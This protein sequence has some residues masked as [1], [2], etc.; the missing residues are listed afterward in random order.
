MTEVFIPA[1]TRN[2]KYCMERFNAPV[3]FF[4]DNAANANFD[5]RLIVI[6]AADLSQASFMESLRAER[7]LNGNTFIILTNPVNSPAASSLMQSCRSFNF[8]DQIVETSE[9]RY[10]DDSNTETRHLYWERITDIAFE[11]LDRVNGAN[12]GLPQVYLAQTDDSQSYDRDN[13][14]RDLSDMGYSVVPQVLISNNYDESVEQITTMLSGASLFIHMIPASYSPYFANKSISIVEH[15]CNLSA[16]LIGDGRNDIRRIIWIP[17]DYD[18][19]DDKNQ[20]FIEK[21]QRDLDQ[22][23]NTLVLKVTL[24]DLKKVYR[25]MLLGEDV[26]NVKRTELPGVYMIADSIND[27]VK[28]QIDS[29]AQ[30]AG[31]KFGINYN[32][33]SYNDHLKYLASAQVVVINYTHE[34]SQWINVKVHDVLKSPGL[35]TSVPNKKLVLIKNSK[36]LD[37]SHFEQ[38]FNEVRVVEASEIKLNVL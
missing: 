35:D 2:L 27:S 10:F 3:E 16:K 36:D 13:I 12:S 15:Q 32:G 38:F 29:E 17:S 24:E 19:A 1:F 8:W 22:S 33:I 18:I 20:I 7:C 30:A 6:S 37:T 34:N 23:H 14:K 31:L 9:I 28:T 11:I 5:C 25:K 26:E 4:T 21:I